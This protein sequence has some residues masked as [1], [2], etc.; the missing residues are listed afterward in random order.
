MKCGSDPLQ[1]LGDSVE[2]DIVMLFRLF[3]LLF[4]ETVDV[5][6]SGLKSLSGSCEFQ[7]V[8]PGDLE[9]LL[10]FLDIF[11]E[12]LLLQPHLFGLHRKRW[13][14]ECCLIHPSCG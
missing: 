5:S 6:P 11:L 13:L 4:D 3:V 2:D 9:W 7:G 1:C 10:H 12:L 14:L 8:L